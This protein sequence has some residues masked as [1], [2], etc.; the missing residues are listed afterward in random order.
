ML[1]IHNG[2]SSANIA[3]RS[4]LPG[5]H[6]AWR[7]ALIDG[8][9]PAGVTGEQWLSLRAHHLTEF[10]GIDL[11]EGESRL[12]A[13]EEKLAS[14]AEH[15]EVVLWFEHDLFC[16]TN[17]LYLL[18]WFADRRLGNTKLGLICI[19]EFPGQ[20]SFRGLGELSPE[21]MASLYD[22]RC[23]VSNVEKALASAAWQ[24]YCSPDPTV[25]RT[26][27]ETDT[28]GMPFLKPALQL[29]LE[30]F[31][32]VS[33]GLGRIQN[34]GL[35]FIHDGIRSF[36]DL[37][38]RFGDAEPAYGLGD[39]QFWNALRQMSEAH[40]PL[41]STGNGD[42]SDPKLTWDNV[43]QMSFEITEAGAAVLNAQADFVEMN[44][45]DTWLGGVHLMGKDTVWRW[46]A[47]AQ[48]LT[49]L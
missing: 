35:Q 12:R 17:L 26:L 46:D 20:P 33:N 25:I 38:P 5:E 23:E 28:S 45:I 16:Q 15:N 14:Y 37:F 36:V 32:S 42:V 22:G 43:R 31:P 3:R 7:E 44:G 2:D 1:H 6:L 49:C 41:L 11:S 18:N 19:G 48:N 21:Q 8:P 9:T 47:Q 4:S 30:R 34:R 24:A 40:V 10:Y 29:H 39:A 13:Q 27:L